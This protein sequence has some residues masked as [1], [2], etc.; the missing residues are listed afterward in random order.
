MPRSHFSVL[1]T[2]K[3]KIFS[4]LQLISGSIIFFVLVISIR[5]NQNDKLICTWWRDEGG[6]GIPL[7]GSSILNVHYPS[8]KSIYGKK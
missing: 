6:S 5:L 7:Q 2:N 3:L 8:T 1:A 4:L